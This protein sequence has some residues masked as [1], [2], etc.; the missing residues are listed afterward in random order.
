MTATFV[1]DRSNRIGQQLGPRGARTRQRLM[2]AA[3]RLLETTS[4]IDLSTAAIAREAG[5]S[6]ATYYVYFNDVRELVLALLPSAEPDFAAMFPRSDSLL[7]ADLLEEDAEN[8]V[9]AV[10]EAWDRYASILLFRNL[11]ADRGDAAFDGARYAWARPVLD[12]LICAIEAAR[13]EVCPNIAYADAV[14][15]LAMIER[16]AATSHRKPTYGPPIADL[17]A[18]L[19]RIIR[20][21]LS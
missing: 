1:P 3:R 6:A 16:I 17:R 18:S 12:R 10:F 11:E 15:L 5:A 7:V 8:L 4:P 2:D 9:A 21:S 19:V 14:V 20:Q 13:G